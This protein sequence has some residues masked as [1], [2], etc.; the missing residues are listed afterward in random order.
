MCLSIINIVLST[1][2]TINWTTVWMTYLCCPFSLKGF[3]CFCL[4]IV[5]QWSEVKGNSEQQT[6]IIS[7]CQRI[8][9]EHSYVEVSHDQLSKDIIV[10]FFKLMM[11]FF[12]IEGKLYTVRRICERSCFALPLFHLR[13]DQADIRWTLLNLRPDT[14]HH[15]PSTVDG[16]CSHLYSGC[17]NPFSHTIFNSKIEWIKR[18]LITNAAQG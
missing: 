7:P 16:S 17:W 3:L 2:H 11:F 12:L 10:C 18:R 13:A 1:M 14:I 5:L 6:R 15:P 9:W 4:F 8:L